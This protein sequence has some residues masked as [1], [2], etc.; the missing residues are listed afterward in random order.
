VL[1]GIVFMLRAGLP[2]RLLPARELVAGSPVTCW[3]RLRDRQAAGVWQQLHAALLNELGRAEGIDWSRVCLDS[4]S[5][6]AKRGRRADRPQPDRPRQARLEVPPGRRPPRHPAGGGVVGGQHPRLAAAGSHGGCDPAGQEA[7]GPPPQT[8]RQAPRRQGLRLRALPAG[9]APAGHHTQDRPARD[10]A[11]PEA[12]PV[13]VGGGAHPVTLPTKRRTRPMAAR[14]RSSGS[15]GC[16]TC[17][18]RLSGY[19]RPR[20][21]G[22]GERSSHVWPVRRCSPPP[23]A[24]RGNSQWERLP[25]AHRQRLLWLL[26]L[27][28]QLLER[29]LSRRA[30]RDQEGDHEPA[31]ARG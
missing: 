24:G 15:A 14:R 25:L 10:R 30:D 17:L 12:R 3:R 31:A 16:C 26:W 6:R 5:V 18:R 7:T 13:S 2:W 28:S 22:E 20:L 4:L 21:H 9:I 27:L 23:G 29:Q 1:G 11:Q 19:G 8:P